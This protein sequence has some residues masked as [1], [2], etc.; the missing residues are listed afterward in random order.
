MARIFTIH[1]GVRHDPI[2]LAAQQRQNHGARI[3]IVVNHS[4]VDRLRVA[5]STGFSFIVVTIRVHRPEKHRQHN[6]RG[7]LKDQRNYE[8]LHRAGF[9]ATPRTGLLINGS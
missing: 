9:E 6:Y 2:T 8:E 4:H 5:A 1:P 3:T 7:L